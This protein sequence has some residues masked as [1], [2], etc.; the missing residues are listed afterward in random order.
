MDDGMKAV[1]HKDPLLWST[2]MKKIKKTEV[3]YKAK[4]VSDVQLFFLVSNRDV[5][6]FYYSDGRTLPS[7]KKQTMFN[8]M[9]CSV[10]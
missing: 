9:H 7:G 3:L 2:I 5:T 8:Y 4:R 1:S 6:L 10:I